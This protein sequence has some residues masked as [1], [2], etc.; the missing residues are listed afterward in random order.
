[1]A[2]T[3]CS[4]EAQLREKYIEMGYKG[5]ALE[6]K[7]EEAKAQMLKENTYFDAKDKYISGVIKNDL[8]D[9]IYIYK[10]RGL[11]R[12][13]VA[14][15][16]KVKDVY[17]DT[18]SGSVK[19]VL[20]DHREYTFEKGQLD[21]NKTKSYKKNGKVILGYTIQSSSIT[22]AVSKGLTRSMLNN[23]TL[24]PEEAEELFLN[25]DTTSDTIIN[26]QKQLQTI[27]KKSLGGHHDSAH[28]KY[29]S[30]VVENIMNMSK[31]IKKLNIKVSTKTV[32]SLIEPLGEFNPNNPDN[33]IKILTSSL[34]QEI[35]NKF[36]MTN[37]EALT[38]EIVHAALDW[39]FKTRFPGIE[40]ENLK[41][42]IRRLYNQAKEEMTW[43][44]LLDDNTSYTKAEELKAKERYDHVFNLT[45]ER[46]MQSTRTGEARLQ[47]FMAHLMTNKPFQNGLNKLKVNTFK[48][49][50]KKN[51]NIVEAITRKLFD[52]LSAVF[53]K[54][55]KIKGDT[56]LDESVKVVYA[57]TKIQDK[58]GKI[59][60]AS[61]EVSF[62]EKITKG[63][64]A[65]TN[66][67]D[68]LLKPSMDKI[69]DIALGDPKDDIT[70]KDMKKELSDIVSQYHKVKGNS[71][72]EII[73]IAKASVKIRKFLIVE[74]N[75]GEE[76]FSL[77]LSSLFYSMGL[78]EDSFIRKLIADFTSGRKTLEEITDDT[79]RFRYNLD[80]L[81]EQNYEGT[82]KDIFND[83]FTKIDLFK[84]S[85]Q[86]YDKALGDTVMITDIQSLLPKD[87]SILDINLDDLKD[88]IKIL[89]KR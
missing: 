79:M 60:A 31:T 55:R 40:G 6:L 22:D 34:G 88:M 8:K 43:K 10:E 39:V 84:K 36:H 14:E 27:D 58:Y 78:D 20:E 9:N 32:D 50:I 62:D 5:D 83:M 56:L 28:S 82:L 66:K 7:I 11:T 47:E 42:H 44:D 54:H 25:T 23:R 63:F 86:K 87:E 1:M 30:T 19:I 46:G 13:P 49:E 38:H 64:N 21:S 70:L 12:E 74:K 57:L 72:K 15:L 45:D 16:V 35:R 4:I 29:L 48:K 85:N 80:R 26:I 73:Y 77:M 51:E 69:A 76:Q 3:E 37:E 33:P 67:I 68:S 81:R 75:I 89:A 61:R 17:A 18:Q 65:A 24:T 2:N 71:F 59:A 41:A 52:F 53:H